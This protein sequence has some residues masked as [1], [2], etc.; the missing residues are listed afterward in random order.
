MKKEV[1]NRRKTLILTVSHFFLLNEKACLSISF[2]FYVMSV[3][4]IIL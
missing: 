4:N 1:E 2:L 3:F